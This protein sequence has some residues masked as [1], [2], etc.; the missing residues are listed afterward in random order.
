MPTVRV[1]V[2]VWCSCGEGLCD[3]ASEHPRKQGLIVEPC[4]LCVEAAKEEAYKEGF[5]DGKYER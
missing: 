3:K 2:E 4:K 1:D 5:E